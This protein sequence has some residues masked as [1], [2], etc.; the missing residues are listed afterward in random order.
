MQ[1]YLYLKD[2]QK[3][4]KPDYVLNPKKTDARSSTNKNIEQIK[5]HQYR[6]EA[7]PPHLLRFHLQLQGSRKAWQ[8]L[9]K[10]LGKIKVKQ[11][12]PTSFISRPL[13]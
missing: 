1:R 12:E 7:F 10:D 11:W 4:I 6:P 8:E 9:G 2:D 5:D 13:L 3:Q